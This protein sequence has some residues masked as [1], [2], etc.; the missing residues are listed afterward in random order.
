[1]IDV[2]VHLRDGVQQAKETIAHALAVGSQCGIEAFFDM[3]NTDP[4]LIS[5]PEIDQRI[6][7]GMQQAASIDEHIFYGV[8]A[9]ITSDVKQIQNMIDLYRQRHPRI[10]GFK[11]FAGHSTGNMGLVDYDRQQVVYQTLADCGYCGVLA[12]HCEKESL[13]RP[14]RWDSLRPWTHS[15]ARP[16]EAEVASISDQIDMVRSSGYSGRLHICHISTEDSIGLVHKARS[17]GMKISCG[18]T[19]HHALLDMT[20]AGQHW[21]MLKMNPPLRSANDRDAVYDGLLSGKID[22]IE[23]DHAPHTVLDKIAG[24]SGIPALAGILLLISA[25]RTSGISQSRLE[26][27]CYKKAQSVFALPG[28][29]LHIPDEQAIRERLQ[30]IKHAYSWDPF[31]YYGLLT[32]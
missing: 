4:P 16:A 17:E 10:V 1:V 9:G 21:N 7:F 14:E 27:L 18:A 13:L 11:M 23:S 28:S 8:Y 20:S 26:D 24:A 25:L 29:Y 31:A 3:P 30:H 32:T 2:H 6:R 19:P 22:W 15:M 5:E 12:V